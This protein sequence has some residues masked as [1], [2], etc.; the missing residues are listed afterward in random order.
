MK[1]SNGDMSAF[2][3]LPENTV[4]VWG[5]SGL[6]TTKDGSNADLLVSTSTREDRFMDKYSFFVSDDGGDW[7]P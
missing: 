3:R 2:E 6:K 1:L 4:R 5:A 7:T